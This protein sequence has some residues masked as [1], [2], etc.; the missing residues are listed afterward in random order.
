MTKKIP[1]LWMMRFNTEYEFSIVENLIKKD[2]NVS[3]ILGNFQTRELLNKF[4]NKH[5]VTLE[6]VDSNEAMALKFNT[7]NNIN[8][9]NKASY[10][11]KKKLYKTF[12]TTLQVM[13]R[14]ER[15][16]GE[17]S[18][19]ER[20]Y[21]IYKQVEFWQTKIEEKKPTSI[22]FFDVP[23]QYYEQIILAI[24]EEKNIPCMFLSNSRN[25]TLFINNKHQLI[26]G[27][28]GKKFSEVNNEFF[29]EVNQ[30]L[31]S[32]TKFKHPNKMPVSVSDLFKQFFKILYHFFLNRKK[33][34]THGSFI[35]KNYFEFGFNNVLNQSINL[36]LYNWNCLKLR[37]LYNKISCKADYGRDFVYMP[38]VGGF[39]CTLHPVT[40][41]LN[42]FIILDHLT[43]ILPENCSIYI[44]EH[45]AQFL[46]RNHQRF[47]RSKEFY[48]KI[49]KMKRVKFI[50]IN[51]NHYK[52]IS[53]SRF[54][55]GSSASSVAIESVAL[56]KTYKYYGFPRYYSQYIEP[57][58]NID[59]DISLYDADAYHEE[60][61]YRNSSSDPAT[62]ANK[63][64]LWAQDNL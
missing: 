64:I 47:A 35:K 39:E 49:N 25:D 34:Y 14:Y 36:F 12:Y 1:N 16:S 11:F 3:L 24:C 48:L 43:N 58:F 6:F 63:I 23:H 31:N 56:K 20:N 29:N 61:K 53:K 17:L 46:F 52:L 7:T 10:F 28:G 26:S 40:S 32:P 2:I 55:V 54:V 4:K 19:E 15:Y 37:R 60:S 57:L 27:Y 30:N 22:I 8:S 45:P 51:E 50:D 13:E 21:I 59:S 42:Y 44:R 9:K 41:P 33:D 18:F 38:L 5:Q 62:L